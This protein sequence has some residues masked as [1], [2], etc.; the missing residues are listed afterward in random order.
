MTV[1]VV[2][3]KYHRPGGL[4]TTEIYFSQFWRQ[5]SPRSRYWQ[6]LCLLRAC[7]LFVSSHS[8]DGVGELSRVSF[9]RALI[10][11]MGTPPWWP[12]YFQKAPL[13]NTIML[14][15]RVSTHEFRWGDTNIWSIAMMEPPAA[16]WLRSTG[17]SP[18]HVP[19]GWGQ[20]LEAVI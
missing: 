4:Q 5:E 6:I 14:G 1:L 20:Y 8:V 17:L 16:Y 9:I 10:L 15:V 19:P 13:S 12:N 11:F 2:L 7:L 18:K 3:T